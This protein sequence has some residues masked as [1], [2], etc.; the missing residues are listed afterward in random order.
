MYCIRTPWLP[1]TMTAAYAEPG[2]R[3]S[4]MMMPAFVHGCGPGRTEAIRSGG[5]PP[6]GCRA[7]P[8][9]DV[10]ATVRLPLP[11]SG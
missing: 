2:F 6:G 1:V 11:A 3:L 10:T 8:V 5:S 9:R 4:L 7:L